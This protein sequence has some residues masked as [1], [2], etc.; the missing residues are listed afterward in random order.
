MVKI[1]ELDNRN[2]WIIINRTRRCI[3]PK[4]F[5]SYIKAK[6]YIEK[7]YEN[8]N[9]LFTDDYHLIIDNEESYEIVVALIEE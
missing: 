5:K 6:N 9:V 4:V 2:I 1:I 8:R 7:I 3:V